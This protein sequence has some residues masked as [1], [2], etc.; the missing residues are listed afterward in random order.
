MPSQIRCGKFRGAPR[1]ECITPRQS[2]QCVPLVCKK[3]AE[4]PEFR[5]GNFVVNLKHEISHAKLK[6]HETPPPPCP[7][8]LPARRRCTAGAAGEG[9]SAVG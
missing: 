9:E 6:C 7:G 3:F 4:I 8:T 1:V 2:P 5:V